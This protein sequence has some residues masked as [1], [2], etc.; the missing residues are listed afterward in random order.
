M[1]NSQPQ[2][3]A[4][5]LGIMWDRLVSLTD[6]I[7]ASLVRSSFSTIV[8]ESHDLSVVV[9]DPEGNVIAQGTYSLPA[10]TGTAAPTLRH[11]LKRFPPDTLR[12]GDVIATNDPWIGTGH[13][14]DI[15][16][17]R[18][19][20]R[21]SRLIGYT[22]SITHLP[23]IGGLG[24]SA[25][26]TDIFVEGLRLPVC[27]LVREGKVD[28]FILD[29][30]RANSRVPDQTVGD[31]TANITCNEVGGRQL[32]EFMDVYGVDDLMPLSRAIRNQAATAMREKI[33]G[34]RD[35]TYSYEAD[36]EGV[37][38]AIRLVCSVTV[39][40]DG[41]VIDFE[42][43]SGPV[44]RG[45]NVPFCY[46]RAMAN[47]AVKCLTIP[48][49]PNNEGA[50]SPITV[51]APEGCIVNALPPSPT[52]GRHLVGHFVTPAVFNALA[53]VVPSMVQA[54]CGMISDLNCQGM[55]RDGRRISTLYYAAGGFGALQN[56]DGA[57]TTP[58][59][60]NMSVVPV[61]IWESLTSM[62]IER[63]RLLVDSG[64]AGANRG[65]LGQEIILRN[66]TGHPMTVFTMSY[67]TQ[68]PSRGL[69]GGKDGS[70][71]QNMINGETVHPKGQFTL[72]P[73][74]RISLVEAGGGGFGKP[75]A[76][77]RDL[78]LRDVRDGFVSLQS[79]K[80]DYGVDIDPGRLGGPSRSSAT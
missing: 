55:H 72:Q 76:R 27:R 49:I 45:I 46:T 51:T 41:V 70:L 18:P 42:G 21:S 16:V 38:E 61:E 12:P 74:D 15:T 4:V 62:T 75:T 14:F 54:D 77:A 32:L 68:F 57:A 50:I 52:G 6:E 34:W 7:L 3:D 17:M 11:M 19:V 79:A 37:D 48:N 1:A 33:R 44:P 43:T 8:R 13:L 65:G 2:I 24:Y 31:I 64:G 40:G 60:T 80:C 10:F 47:Y 5:S 67:R 20:F 63:K 56:R 23:D 69:L 35:G 26:A 71:R 58:G 28:D 66:D 9:L 22:M 73:G 53:E 39:D 36:V 59:P 25:A 30:I 78:V 29:L